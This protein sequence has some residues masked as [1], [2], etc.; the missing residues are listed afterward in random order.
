MVE[1]DIIK[2]KEK[3]IKK[4]KLICI[5]INYFIEKFFEILY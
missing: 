3:E 2:K 4:M 5:L 1:K